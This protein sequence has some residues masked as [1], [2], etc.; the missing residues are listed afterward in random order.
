MKTDTGEHDAPVN[1]PLTITALGMGPGPVW[2]R[3]KKTRH[4]KISLG[5]VHGCAA[6]EKLYLVPSAE[7]Q[8]EL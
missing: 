5:V 3:L 2:G 4:K 1:L 7:Y 8:T 6:S